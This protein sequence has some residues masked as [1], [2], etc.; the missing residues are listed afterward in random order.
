MARSQGGQ[1]DRAEVRRGAG[2]VDDRSDYLGR[3]G[4]TRTIIQRARRHAVL[5]DQPDELV[6]LPTQHTSTLP[7]AQD[8]RFGL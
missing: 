4:F 8:F 3:N 5:L 7:Q 2:P 1:P 6:V